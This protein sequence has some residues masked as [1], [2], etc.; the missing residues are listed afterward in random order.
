MNHE[1]NHETA[2]Q[3]NQIL[4]IDDDLYPLKGHIQLLKSNGYAVESTDNGKSGVAMA[5]EMKPQ[6]IL[7]DIVMPD[8]DG[9]AVCRQL[10]ET[11]G[12]KPPYIVMLSAMMTEPEALIKGLKLGANDYLTKPITKEVLMARVDT[13]FRMIRAER[14]KADLIDALKKQLE[15]IRIL[16]GFVVI[17]SHC[18]SIRSDEGNWD[19]IEKYVADHSETVFSHSICPECAKTFYP[20]YDIYDE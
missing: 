19:Q 17:C 18:K 16:R 4:I 14:E 3:P 15:E 6:L 10:Y 7:L 2:P 12:F 13:I 8:M 5:I 11:P 9:Y 1:L 20:D